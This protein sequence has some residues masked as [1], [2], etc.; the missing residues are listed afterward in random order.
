MYARFIQSSVVEA[1]KYFPAIL[2]TGPRQCGKSTLAM[3]LATNYITL[4]D[5]TALASAKRDP[6]MFI[7]NLKLP[8]VIDEIQK[9]PELLS[10]IKMVID[11]DRKPGQFILTG[12]ANVLAFNQISDSLAGRIA[13]FELTPLSFIELNGKQTT[14]VEQLFSESCS[15]TSYDN[16]SEDFIYPRILSGCYPEMLSIGDGRI[17]YLWLSSYVATYLERDV[18]DIENI[19]H[20]DK[21]SRLIHL[22]ASR[23]G[24]LINKSELSKDAGLDTKTLDNYL[25]LL[26]LIYQVKRVKPYFSNIG[27]RLVKSEKLYFTDS[28]ILNFLLGN[29]T[30]DQMKSS[31]LMGQVFET[32]VFNELYKQVSYLLDGTQI[33]YYR[34]HDQREI[35]FIIER[36]GKLI[37]IEVK[38]A[39]T[40]TQNDFKH[41]IDLKQASPNFHLGIVIYM[42]SL[43]VS[44]G[45]SLLAIPFS[46][47]ANPNSMPS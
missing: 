2:I 15:L 22:L 38:L 24:A 4:D 45:D 32:F 5:I 43:T 46:T 27:K 10:A 29:Q 17:R 6:Q 8:I 18:R 13:L 39:K 23:S 41:I 20:I 14:F 3:Q 21:F 33:Y 40:V 35:D 7:S 44:F 11:A 19:R 42:G 30:V 25:N 31:M 34:T 12:S 26:S 37:A 47:L 9:A 1:L 28:G 36:H 16:I